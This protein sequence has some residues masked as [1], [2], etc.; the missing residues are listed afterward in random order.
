M[1]PATHQDSAFCFA[2]NEATLREYIEPI[3]GWDV[4]LQRE[5]HPGW[6][7]PDRLRIILDDGG[8]PAGVLDVSDESDG[9]YLSRIEIL[10]EMQVMASGQRSSV[11]S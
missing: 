10:P 4:D 7:D 6:F 9:L 5:H 2:L 8:R 11:V 1:S 3:Y